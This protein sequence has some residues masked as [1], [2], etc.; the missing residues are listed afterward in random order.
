[1]GT[2]FYDDGVLFSFALRLD[3][4]KELQIVECFTFN[5][6]DLSHL[7]TVSITPTTKDMVCSDSYHDMASTHCL[8][9]YTL[10]TPQFSNR[11]LG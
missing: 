10:N 3:N 2:L 9:S 7:V 8:H 4:V 6:L 5:T 1:M 11:G